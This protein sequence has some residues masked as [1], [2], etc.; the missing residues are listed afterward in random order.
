MT[1][2]VYRTAT[3]VNGFIADQDNSLAWLFEVADT[4]PDMLA[5]MVGRFGVQVMGSTTYQWLVEHENV[6]AEPAKWQAF[7]GDLPTRI[8]SSRRLDLPTGANV[9]VV[10]GPVADQVA[11]LIE[12]AEGK[13]VWIV[14]GG[15]LAGQFL[16][17]GCLDRIEL[18]MAP[19]FL[20]AGAPLLPRDV[21]SDRLRLSAVEAV[22]PF[23]RLAY[24]VDRPRDGAESDDSD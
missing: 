12:A 14:G 13:D 8:F 18:D 11:E 24:D 9:T 19:A 2:F 5:D 16:D 20:R 4:D 23:V 3:T 10:Q 17:A 15:D 6:V 1:R 22:G 7:F 21:P